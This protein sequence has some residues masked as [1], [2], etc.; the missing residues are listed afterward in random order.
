MWPGCCCWCA[1][2]DHVNRC[3]LV[4]TFNAYCLQARLFYG[5]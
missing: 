4:L 1:G 5:T 2:R 3:R